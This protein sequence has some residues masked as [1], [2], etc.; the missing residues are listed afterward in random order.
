MHT[1]ITDSQTT[2]AALTDPDWVRLALTAIT[3]A[4]AAGLQLAAALVLPGRRPRLLA[5]RQNAQIA[6]R[7]LG[8]AVLLL[9]LAAFTEAYWSSF[10]SI[11]SLSKYLI[12]SLLWLLVSL[13]F[14]RAGRPAQD[15]S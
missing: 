7:L 5:L 11:G 12:G 15:H 3:L 6:I 10:R 14:L 9:V 8:G 2:K 13:Y 1:V 4:G